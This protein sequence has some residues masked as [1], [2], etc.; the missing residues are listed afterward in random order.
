MAASLENR[1]RAYDTVIRWGGDEFLVILPQTDS[2]SA[3]MVMAQVLDFFKE[4]TDGL[5]FS[6]GLAALHEDETAAHLVRRADSRLLDAKA[7]R[8]R[9]EQ[10][11]EQE[12]PPAR[13]EGVEAAEEPVPDGDGLRLPAQ[14]APPPKHPWREFLDRLVGRA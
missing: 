11:R 6:F 10:A 13:E 3:G 9:A 5:S 2:D 14:P 1:L 8:Q 12:P 7:E 4:R